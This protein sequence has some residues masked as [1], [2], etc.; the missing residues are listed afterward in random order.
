MKI[1]CCPYCNNTDP[2]VVLWVK[3]R[4]VMC[5]LCGAL[6][7]ACSDKDDAIT[8]WNRVSKAVKFYEYFKEHVD[9]DGEDSTISK[10]N[11]DE[12]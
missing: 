4:Q 2:K 3:D 6:G 7:S 1:E 10:F 9:Y 12:G 5:L 11:S 8:A